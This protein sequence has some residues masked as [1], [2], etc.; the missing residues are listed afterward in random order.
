M[1]ARTTV[2]VTVIP[3]APRAAL[4]PSPQPQLAWGHMYSHRLAQLRVG[5]LLPGLRVK[6]QVCVCPSLT[7]PPA[8]GG[9]TPLWA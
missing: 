7:C 4:P 9:P 8:P 5:P 6:E 3:A 1:I 2:N